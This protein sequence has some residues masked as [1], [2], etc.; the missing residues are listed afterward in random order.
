MKERTIQSVGYIEEKVQVKGRAVGGEKWGM[1]E[2]EGVGR[3][4]CMYM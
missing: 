3:A 4:I 2:A 1:E